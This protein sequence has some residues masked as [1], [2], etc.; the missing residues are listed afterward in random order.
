MWALQ[1]KKDEREKQ[2]STLDSVEKYTYV[3]VASRPNKR[4]SLCVTVSEYCLVI[5]TQG[6]LNIHGHICHRTHKEMP[7]IFIYLSTVHLVHLPMLHTHARTH[8]H[9]P[10]GKT[11]RDPPPYPVA[12][13]YRFIVHVGDA[14]TRYPPLESEE[15]T[16]E[17][18]NQAGC[19]SDVVTR[20]QLA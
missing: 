2:V 19:F 9:M 10:A 18:S 11:D 3:T 6:L 1:G 4:D 16:K 14:V 15:A 17:S 13:C 20:V 7:S 12:I 8:T 5:L